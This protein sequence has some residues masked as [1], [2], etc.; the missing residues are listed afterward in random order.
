MRRTYAALFLLA[1]ASLGVELLLTRIFDV[2]LWPN[3]SFLIISCAIFGLGL[4]GLFEVLHPSIGGA[5]AVAPAYGFSLTVWAVPPLLNAIPFSVDRI[6]THPLAQLFWFLA[7][8]VVLLAPFFCVG[9]C[10]CR[11]F[12]AASGD[13]RHLYFFDLS[14]A[15]LG[16]A[17]VIP[18]IQPAG[19]ERLMI[20]AALVALTAACLLARSRRSLLPAVALGTLFVIGAAWLGPRYLRLALHDDKRGASSEAALG[21][22]EF[23]VWDPVSQIAVLD[24]PP[25]AGLP[26]DPGRKHIA[27]D[28]GSQTSNFFP[29]DGDF[30]TLRRELP[31]RLMSQ[32]WQRGVLASHYLRRDTGSCVLIIG[33]AGG[34]ETKAA[35]LF[36]AR[37]VDAVEMVGTVVRLATEGYAA[38]IGHLFERPQVH[39]YVGEGRSFLRASAK[40]YDIIQI[41]SNY[42]S[43]SIAEGSGA[44]TPSYLLTREAFDDY[45]GHLSPNGILQINHIFYPRI[46]T[47][48][49]AAWA[50][51]DRDDFRRH[52]VVF[53]KKAPVRD[54]LPSVLIKRSPWTAG[55]VADLSRFFAEPSTGETPYSLAED[56]LHPERSFLPS[57]FYAPSLPDRLRREAPYDIRPVTD[58]RPFFRFIRRSLRGVTEERRMGVDRSTAWAL[59]TQLHGGWLPRDWLHLIAATAVSLFYGMLF[60]IAPLG[61][62]AVGRQ[63]WS[64]KLPTLWYFSLL[65]FGFITIELVLIQMF[66][67]VIG[68]PLYAVATV[69]TVMLVGAAVGSMESWRVVGRHSARWAL[70]FGGVI[71][72]GLSLLAAMPI[73]GRLVLTQPMPTRILATTV[74]IAPLAFFMGMPFPLGILELAAKPRGAVAWAWSMNGLFTTAGAVL[75]ALLSLWVGFRVTALIALAAYA[76]AAGL[77]APLRRSNRHEVNDT[78]AGRKNSRLAPG[79]GEFPIAPQQTRQNSPACDSAESVSS[80]RVY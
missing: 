74:M 58:D 16:T 7:L 40:R 19:P 72:A 3:L 11:I 73:V 24:Q 52:V 32:F 23:S 41:F 1:V 59:N 65:G 36:G 71:L 42:T 50:D 44:L 46:V 37:D 12:S 54:Y 53:E 75:S 33:S 67:R 25:V 14:G 22:L 80:R 20:A 18:L 62:S 27:Y 5:S 2:I 4:G 21:R 38:Y 26:A 69:L 70:A 6:G 51:V 79:G 31:R 17:A 39:A 68:Y 30:E 47:T 49:A 15:A 28:G 13:I 9:L 64:G 43:S 61:L 10:V 35:L 76:V 55:E 66:M 57:S 45:F 29:F 78:L 56:P 63:S 60:V 77:F 8:Y 34:Q 48:A